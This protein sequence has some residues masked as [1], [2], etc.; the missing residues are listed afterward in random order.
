MDRHSGEPICHPQFG[1]FVSRFR[2]LFGCSVL[3]LE[4]NCFQIQKYSEAVRCFDY[5]RIGVYPENT[6]A[7]AW[8]RG[9]HG[10]IRVNN[11]GKC[12]ETADPV[13]AVGH[14]SRARRGSGGLCN[15]ES[16]EHVLYSDG[17][18]WPC[19]LG[20]VVEGMIGIPP[21]HD[22]KRE[23]SLLPIPCGNCFFSPDV[24]LYGRYV[25]DAA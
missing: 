4:T 2:T 16:R 21:S 23:I 25:P 12:V 11:T 20:P 5:I 13:D 24:S 15:L 14:V 17:K 3:S 8:L 6:E 9:H 7:V 22:W 10:D 19:R 1:E 18:F